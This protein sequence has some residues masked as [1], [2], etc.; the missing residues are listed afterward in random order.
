VEAVLFDHAT[1]E[2]NLILKTRGLI[3]DSPEAEK[4]TIDI[5]EKWGF[6]FTAK[7]KGK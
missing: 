6:K 7:Q 5:F 1:R 3:I 2:L 4:I